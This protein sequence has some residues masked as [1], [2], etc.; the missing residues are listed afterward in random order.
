MAS[1]EVIEARDFRF[2]HESEVAG[3]AADFRSSAQT[4]HAR[5]EATALAN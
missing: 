3:G 4:G 2:W 5:Y 1:V